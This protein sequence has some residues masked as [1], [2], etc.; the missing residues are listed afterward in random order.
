MS[1]IWI[2]IV[3]HRVISKG[4]DSITAKDK[5]AIYDQVCWLLGWR[6]YLLTY[7]QLQQVT[8]YVIKSKGV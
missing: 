7:Q 4:F 8:D 3:S 2:A 6:K 5:N 1:D